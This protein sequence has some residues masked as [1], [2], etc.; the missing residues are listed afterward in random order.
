MKRISPQR[1]GSALIA[2]VILTLALSGAPVASG[3]DPT[4]LHGKVF[5]ACAKAC[6]E[7]TN[8]C[9]SCYHHCVELVS[10]GKKD[11]AQTLVL[12]NDCAE[13]CSTAAKL[14]SRHSPFAAAICDTCATSCDECQTACKKFP[15]DKHMRSCAMA[16]KDCAAACREMI[17]HLA[18]P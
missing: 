11:H 10:D 13:V 18:K 9:A 16:C 2:L 15:D 17:K 4:D 7:C 12:C 14:T 3:D 6:A 8:S 5:A 1:I